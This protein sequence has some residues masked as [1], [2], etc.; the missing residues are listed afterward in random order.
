MEFRLIARVSGMIAT[1]MAVV[2]PVERPSH[3]TK[4]V[5]PAQ[6]SDRIYLDEGPLGVGA[7]ARRRILSGELILT[8][9]GPLIDFAAAVRKGDRECYPLQIAPNLYIDLESP[10]CFANHSCDPNAGVR[11]G[12]LWAIRDISPDTEIRY[13]YSTTMDEDHFRMGCRCQS[14]F[15]RGTVTDFKLLPE[16]VRSRY[17]LLG[18]VQPFIACQYPAPL[19]DKRPA[20]KALM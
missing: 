7:F 10:S 12:S 14:E 17:L 8:F 18:V 20:D 1:R 6:V 19:S 13:D 9:T 11:D 16:Q 3:A 4:L 5:L 2:E 15:C